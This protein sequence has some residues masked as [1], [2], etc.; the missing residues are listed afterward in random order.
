MRRLLTKLSNVL[1]FFGFPIV[2]IG[3]FAHKLFVLLKAGWIISR[4][5]DDEK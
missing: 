3:Y 1:I 5:F 2:I 4:D